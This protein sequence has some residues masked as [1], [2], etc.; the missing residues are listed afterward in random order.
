MTVINSFYRN[1]NALVYA[2]QLF[3]ATSTAQARS[4]AAPTWSRKDDDIP[5]SESAGQK[6]LARIAEILALRDAPS[7]EEA[8]VDETLGYITGGQGTVGDDKLTFDAKAVYNIDSG[9]G[10]DTVTAKAS[11]LVSVSTGVGKDSLFASA[12]YIGEIDTGE[13]DDTLK[14]SGDLVVDVTG[15]D[16][17]DTLTVAGEA[18]IGIDGGAGD[19]TM[20]LEGT[21]IFASGG[22]GNDTVSIKR[23]DMKA[24]NAIAEYGFA[25]GDGQ[26]TIN[27]N[28][29]LVL[30]FSGYDEKDVSI[31]V[32]GNTV[33]ATFAGT[34]DR[35]TV[36]L[37]GPAMSGQG[38]T[39]GFSFDHGRTV[40]TIG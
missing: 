7:G 1:P 36:T 15:G 33:T 6:A 2:T 31:S 37:D 4:D 16:G 17:N 20:T 34:A 22:T 11:A 19:D 38:L 40:L 25:R 21:R 26:D 30:R 5:F 10:D 8:S 35:I 18:L 23:T 27:T 12:R 9:G 32:D 3:S 24:D 14:L 39:Y 28:G 13:G 29:S